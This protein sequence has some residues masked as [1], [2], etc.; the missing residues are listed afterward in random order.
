[1]TTKKTAS[2]G[3]RMRPFASFVM[4]T[5]EAQANLGRRRAELDSFNNDNLAAMKAASQIFAAGGKPLVELVAGNA[6]AQVQAFRDAAASLRGVSSPVE[7]FKLQVAAN[8]AAIAAAREDT[9]A[10]G[11][12]VANLA[13]E[14]A[15]PLKDRFAAV[16]K[17]AA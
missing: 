9:R 7:A 16:R 8:K 17:L 3:N 5:K 6:R 2:T 4:R 10:F 15:A 13:A 1:M 14:T 11:R 12:A